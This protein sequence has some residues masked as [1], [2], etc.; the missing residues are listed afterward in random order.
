MQRTAPPEDS[1]EQKWAELQSQRALVLQNLQLK[2]TELETLQQ[3]AQDISR[4]AQRAVLC[5]KDIFREIALLMEK[6]DSEVEQQILSE[7][8]LSRV[9]ELQHQLQQEATELKRSLSKLEELSHYPDHKQFMQCCSLLSTD[10][11]SPESSLQTRPRGDFEFVTRALSVLRAK[12]QQ[13]LSEFKI[14][15]SED[16]QAEPRCR[17]D[18]LRYAQEITLDPNT[19]FPHLHLS[20]GNRKV[21][22]TSKPQKYPDHSDRFSVWSQVLSR[23]ELTGLCY[24]EME[25]SVRDMVRIALSYRDIR[26]K[27]WFILLQSIHFPACFF[28]INSSTQIFK[29]AFTT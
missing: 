8:K 19:A 25:W 3:E 11:H 2:E 24:S 15:S 1:T 21:T 22:H 27:V 20:Q 6:R 23:E 5:S 16:S 17:D 29:T 10:T 18:F 7:T 28:K 26:R 13:T 14:P 9:Q 12:L 4:S